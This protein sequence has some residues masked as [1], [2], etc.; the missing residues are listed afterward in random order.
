MVA[1]Q[2]S[3]TSLRRLGERAWAGGLWARLPKGNRRTT[4]PTGIG[5]KHTWTPKVCKIMAFVGLLL[6]ALG[7]HFT[8]CWDPSIGLHLPT[9]A[10][11]VSSSTGSGK[12]ARVDRASVHANGSEVQAQNC[13]VQILE[14]P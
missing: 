10:F 2:Y 11:W 3:V 14:R 13:V 6:V 8:Y 9:S 7:H 5:S 1:L 12:G 4:S